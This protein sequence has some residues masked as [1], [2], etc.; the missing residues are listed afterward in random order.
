M[1]SCFV[2]LTAKDFDPQ[3]LLFISDLLITDYSSCY[4]DYLLLKRPVI[5][6]FYDSY[7]TEDNELYFTPQDHK[8]GDVCYSEEE[9]L[10][11]IQN[12]RYF[13]SDLYHKYTDSNSSERIFKRIK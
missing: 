6:Y 4:I 5:F 8:V 2:D 10:G 9:L 1:K 7:E 12:P 11:S 3:E 13:D